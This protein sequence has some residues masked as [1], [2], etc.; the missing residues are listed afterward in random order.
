MGLL[1]NGAWQ[2]DISRTKEGRFISSARYVDFAKEFGSMLH[3]CCK[4]EPT[5]VFG[6]RCLQD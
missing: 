6:A 2:E 4:H 1:V 5:M 3:P